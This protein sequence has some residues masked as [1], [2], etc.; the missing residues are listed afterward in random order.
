MTR[1]KAEWISDM[2]V[3][4]QEYDNKLYDK[5]GMS[6]LDLAAKANEI[7]SGR[8][9]DAAKTY[10]VAAIPIAAGEGIISNFSHSVAA[11]LRQLGFKTIVT[12]GTDVNGIYEAYDRRVDCLFMA[13][14]NRFIGIN[15]TKNLISCNNT[16]TAKGYIAA[17]EQMSGCLKGRQVLILGYG[18]I[19]Q[20]ML[21]IIKA[22][23]GIPKIYEKDPSKTAN[24]PSNMLLSDP[25]SI[26]DYPL[27]VDATNTGGWINEG[28]L[29]EEFLMAA[30]GI[31]LS[32]DEKTHL[33]YSERVV[34]D[35]LQIGTAVMMGE[36]CK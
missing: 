31:P 24:L 30:P 9:V 29:H 2:D 4:I 26:K 23:E 17:L 6:L 22:K 5:I 12:E 13:D 16:A 20:L 33:K 36:L 32:L 11:I 3:E 10:K 28:M 19:G 27:I 7:G 8:I 14:D 34:H 21:K 1:L 15:K 18:I 35:W 25:N